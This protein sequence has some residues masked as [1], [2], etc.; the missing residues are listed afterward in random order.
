MRFPTVEEVCAA[1]KANPAWRL[2]D[3]VAHF[4]GD[5]VPQQISHMLEKGGVKMRRGLNFSEH[6]R[7]QAKLTMA[8]KARE[9]KLAKIAAEFSPE[10]IAAARAAAATAAGNADE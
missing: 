8:A 1:Y 7:A 3:M 10:E 2:T 4:N 6:A 5:L 9:R